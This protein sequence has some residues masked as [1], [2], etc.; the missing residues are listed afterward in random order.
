MQGW[1]AFY[2]LIGGASATLMGLLFVAVSLNPA[3]TLGPGHENSGRL[4]EQAFQNYQ[5]VLLVALLALFPEMERWLF[6]LVI[7]SVTGLQ[8]IW[9]LV[10]FYQM[11]SSPA[12]RDSRLFAI[13]RH[14]SSL[15]GFAILIV[16]ALRMGLAGED[17]RNWLAAGT[18]VLLVSSTLVSWELLARIAKAGQARPRK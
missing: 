15:I 4:A 5:A 16:A 8:A 12:G 14:L 9:V 3:Q 13:R 2:A 7:L 17:E 10:R 6:G 1:F 18:I 11:L